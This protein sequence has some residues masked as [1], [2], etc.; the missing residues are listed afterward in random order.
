MVQ[1]VGK[2]IRWSECDPCTFIGGAIRGQSDRYHQDMAC[3]YRAVSALAPPHHLALDRPID[4][5]PNR[6]T[7]RPTS[8]HQSAHSRPSP[9][10]ARSCTASWW[11]NACVRTWCASW[12]DAPAKCPTR[13]VR[14]FGRRPGGQCA[15][16]GRG[17]GPAS[18]ASDS[19]VPCRTLALACA[20]HH[21][22]C[23]EAVRT[24]CRLRRNT[25]PEG[26]RTQA[27][28]WAHTTAG[29]PPTADPRSARIYAATP[30]AK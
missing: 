7:D 17:H 6:L 2:W 3:M 23:R 19:A 24:S 4:C 29:R 25:D 5:P 1:R 28:R 12:Y 9:T 18:A 13:L 16:W 30:F 15:H 21:L 11:E 8:T 27:R 20:V 10:G 26:R 14:A 22:V